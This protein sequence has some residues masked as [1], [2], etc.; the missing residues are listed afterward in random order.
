MEIISS[1]IIKEAL[2]NPELQN[3]IDI[4][5]II[6]NGE[7]YDYLKGKTINT[8]TEEIFEKISEL[9]ITNEQKKDWC[10]KLI[11]YRLINELYELHKGKL[12]KIITLQGKHS[13]HMKGKMA[14]TKFLNNGT[15]IVCLLG[16]NRYSQYKFNDFITFQKLSL[17]EQLIL[18]A[19]EYIHT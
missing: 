1:N 11:G 2:E 16:A 17:E 14:T 3:S 9:D 12:I 18:Q 4:H 19:N 15:H 7:Q 13:I 5:E 8:M 10:D 6:E